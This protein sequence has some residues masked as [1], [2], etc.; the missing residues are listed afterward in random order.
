M[1]TGGTAQSPRITL[2]QGGTHA[3]TKGKPTVCPRLP[4]TTT[5]T[6]EIQ[7]KIFSTPGIKMR[8]I[9]IGYPL[10]NNPSWASALILGIRQTIKRILLIASRHAN[11]I[12]MP[13]QQAWCIPG[14]AHSSLALRASQ[15]SSRSASC[16]PSQRHNTDG[17]GS[18]VRVPPSIVRG[19]SPIQRRRFPVSF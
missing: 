14:R 16:W 17:N 13:W 19:R 8:C 4:A 5:I 6:G 12:W 7:T 9:C 18:S 2:G 3:H 1:Q 15:T 10:L 11:E